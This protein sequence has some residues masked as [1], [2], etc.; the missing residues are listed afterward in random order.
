MA[1]EAFPNVELADEYGLLAIGGDLEVESLLLAYQSG[2]FPWPMSEIDEIPWFSPPER[3]LIFF[4][5]LKI[6]KSLAKRRK[7]CGFNFKIDADFEKVIGECRASK[8][9]KE[10]GQSWITDEME[11][12]Y[13][14]LHRAGH[15]H[16]VACY[17][18]EE[19]LVGG[20]YGVSING[21]FAGESMFYHEPDASKLSLWYLIEHLQS[22][23]ATW[24]D[25]QQLTPLVEKFGAKEIPRSQFLKL[26][27]E[28]LDQQISLF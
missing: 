24:L 13:L 20:I 22:K 2:I 6:S 25:C 26:L 15:A 9:R 3:A 27:D 4:S 8:T 19:Q 11:S 16:C 1:I 7:K 21:M 23:G 10:V 17:N 5:E 28:A 12:A 14:A 18:K